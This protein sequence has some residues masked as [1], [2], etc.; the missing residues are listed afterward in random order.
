MPKN[1]SILLAGLL[2]C[3]VTTFSAVLINDAA[4]STTVA[5]RQTWLAYVANASGQAVFIVD[6]EK[7]GTEWTLRPGEWAAFNV[8]LPSCD[9]DVELA[10]RSLRFYTTHEFEGR[11]IRGVRIFDLCENYRD[12]IAYMALPALTWNDKIQCSAQSFF[13]MNITV[14]PDGIPRC[15]EGNQDLDSAE[16]FVDVEAMRR[17]VVDLAVTS[18]GLDGVNY[19]VDILNNGASGVIQQLSCDN[20]RIIVEDLALSMPI[21]AGETVTVSLRGRS[22]P[23]TYLLCWVY[24]STSAAGLP[25]SP[26]L[27]RLNDVMLVSLKPGPER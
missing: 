17:R 7:P 4:A 11:F 15:F 3:L 8:P 25:M 22:S 19:R 23:R 20:S 14:M 24:G 12:S 13:T 27:F 16:L 1:W 2:A 9:N 5:F 18:I 10:F 6:G 21:Q 26:D